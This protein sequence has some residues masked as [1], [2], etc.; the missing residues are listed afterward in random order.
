VPVERLHL[1]IVL[2]SS[3]RIRDPQLIFREQLRRPPVAGVDRVPIMMDVIPA[4]AMPKLR[5][6]RLAPSQACSAKRVS[7]VSPTAHP[8]ANLL[9]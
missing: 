9:V 5:N 6:I 7:P 4:Q 3:Q 2:G 8:Q 1:W